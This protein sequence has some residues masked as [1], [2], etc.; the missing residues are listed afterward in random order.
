MCG[1]SAPLEDGVATFCTLG[2]TAMP[3]TTA[4]VTF[5]STVG[6]PSLPMPVQM[7]Q[8]APGWKLDT[9]SKTCRECEPGSYTQLENEAKFLEMIGQH[10]RVVCHLCVPN[11][12][13]G[14]MMHAR[15]KVAARRPE[16]SRLPLHPR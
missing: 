3:G 14:E 10:P 1:E 4:F 12:L 13:D 6:Q 11:S 16:L 5:S 2:V 8:C 9:Q 15:L 7:A